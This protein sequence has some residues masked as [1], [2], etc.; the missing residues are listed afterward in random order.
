MCDI[1]GKF[2]LVNIMLRYIDILI[3]IELKKYILGP[4]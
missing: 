4:L 3:N 1:S 2:K